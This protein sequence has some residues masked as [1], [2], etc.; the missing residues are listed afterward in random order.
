[1]LAR[2]PE[3][4]P[5]GGVAKVSGSWDADVKERT[6][7]PLS[8]LSPDA[9]VDARSMELERASRLRLPFAIACVVLA[10]HWRP[11][12]LLALAHAS[13]LRCVAAP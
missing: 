10:T 13:L 3:K 8:H 11:C 5:D 1:M 6:R 2:L 9:K 12:H 7:G 4:Q